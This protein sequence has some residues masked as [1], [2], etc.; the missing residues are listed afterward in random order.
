MTRQVWP[1]AKT[2]L[3]IAL[4]YFFCLPAF[5]QK[6]SIKGVIVD[7]AEK[8]NLHYSI[9]ALINLTDSTLYRSVRTN[10]AGSFK[11]TEIPAGR[12]TLLVSYPKMADYLQDI[13]ITDTSELDVQN[14]PMTTRAQLLQEVIVQ[15]GLP[16]RMRG[17]TLEYTADSFAVKPGAN[18]EELFKRLPG[19]DVDKDGKITAQGQEVKKILVDG[20]EFFSDDPSIAAKYLQAD[21]V[22]K[23]Q[24]F[25][26]KSERA[27]LTGIDDGTRTK[28]VNVK[29]KKNRKNGYFG[30]LSAASDGKDY[31][32]HEAMG[33]LFDGTRKISVFGLSSKTGK[34]GPSYNEL[35]KYTTQDIEAIDDGTGNLIYQSNGDNEN[36]NYRGNGVP[37]VQS[38]GAHY[39]EKWNFDKQ[40]LN[41]NYRIKQFN[42]TGWQKTNSLS[43]LPDGTS[44]NTSTDKQEKS[45]GFMQKANGRFTM[46]L[47]TFTMVKISATGNLS[48]ASEQQTKNSWSTNE[49]GFS[50][51][52]S[53]QTT[54]EANTNK[55]FSSNISVQRKFRKVGRTLSLVV[56][57]DYNNKLGDAYNHSVNNY[58]DPSSGDSTNTDSL[59]Q[60]QKTINSYESYA[61]KIN[62]V[63]KL[64]TNWNLGFE[65]GVKNNISQNVFS[66]LNKLNDKFT[67]RVDTLS[68]DYTFSATTHITGATLVYNQKKL[69]ATLGGNIFFTGFKQTNNDLQDQHTRRFSNFAPLANLIWH[70]K[71]TVGLY[72]SYRGETVQP[73]VE[74][75][76]PLRK[77]SNPLYVQVGNPELQQGF[78][79]SISTYFDKFNVTKGSSLNIGFNFFYTSKEVASK[80]FT[81]ALN[82]STSQFINLNSIPR[83]YSYLYYGWQIKKYNLKP[84][85]NFSINKS[86][87]YSIQND[88]KLKNESFGV[89][90]AFSI[91]HEWKKVMTSGYRGS[92]NNNWGWSDIPGRANTRSFNH[93][94]SVYANIYMPWKMELNSECTFNFQ[95]KNANFNSSI[96]TTQWNAFVQKKLLKNSQA[97][98]KLSVNDILNNNNGYYRSVNG[99]NIYETNR[100]VIKRYWLLSATWN[101][102]KSLK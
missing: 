53:T 102:S 21:A 17:D 29:L 33:A 1:A 98:I 32:N 74:Q 23:V 30:K 101:F 37:S 64:N 24:V 19:F 62:Y 86:G 87:N 70:P 49:K 100:F 66:T 4:C 83:F 84:S 36:E 48:N 38:G 11:I 61:A 54:E 10:S 60:L 16:I 34:Q 72:F 6:N 82:R 3:L 46:K 79:H 89:S 73:T 31:Y 56:Q 57:Q 44:F 85:V 94:H 7:T 42:A 22:D 5:A 75:L 50:V 68:N 78:R 58:F 13:T 69:A 91:N 81:D 12:Y 55:K 20:D 15:A 65:Y 96:N 95:P 2:M 45:Y 77:S 40:K 51:N 63:E 25:D 41:T 18:V 14:I 8:K 92:V 35:S 52:N 28:T 71:Q 90:G 67:E 76:Q 88:N 27:K 47:D 59:N 43:V 99:S 26:D 93:V 9:V 80:T 97:V 39:S